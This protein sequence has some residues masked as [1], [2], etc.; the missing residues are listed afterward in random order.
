MKVY[1]NDEKDLQGL[2][3]L[4]DSEQT[5]NGSKSQLLFLILLFDKKNKKQMITKFFKFVNKSQA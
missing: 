1:L 2:V 5:I 3:A 4:C